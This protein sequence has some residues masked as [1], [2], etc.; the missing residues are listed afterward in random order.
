MP[1]GVEI[2]A[3]G[4]T[5]DEYLARDDW[6]AWSQLINGEV[7]VSEPLLPHQ[8]VLGNLYFQFQLWVRAAPGRGYAGLSTDLVLGARDVYGPDLWWIRE[9]RRPQPGQLRLDGLPDV[10]VE[11]RS[12]S[13]WHYDRGRKRRTYEQGGMP[14]LWLVDTKARV[15]LVY[16]RGQP[17]QAA[18]DEAFIIPEDGTL[19]SPLLPG[20]AL[21]VAAAFAD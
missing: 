7:V 3:R 18:F 8:H 9:E 15:V 11:V 12:Q 16:R 4:V 1:S 21:P 20:F 2:I 10:A 13:T 17:D 6:P 5:A 19:T 14:E